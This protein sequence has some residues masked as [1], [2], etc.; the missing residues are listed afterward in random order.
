MTDEERSQK[1]LDELND[2]EEG[3]R[4]IVIRHQPTGTAQKTPETTGENGVPLPVPDP[5][6]GD[7]W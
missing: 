4:E 7:R 6:V 1:L 2:V 3:L 5:R